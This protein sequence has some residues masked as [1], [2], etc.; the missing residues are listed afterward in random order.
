MKQRHS[1][2]LLSIVFS[3]LC[4]SFAIA[5]SH[6]SNDSLRA[7]IDS[8]IVATVQSKYAASILVSVD[9]DVIL[10]KGYGFA[11]STKQV[12]TTDETLF[13]IASIT[14][15]FTASAI[16]ILEEEGKLHLSDSIS[17]YFH[18]TSADKRAIT[19][20]QLLIHT[21]GLKQ[22]YVSD[23]IVNRDSAVAVILRDTLASKPGKDTSYSNL[24]YEL[25]GA[26]VEIASGKPY[27]EFITKHIFE[28]AHMKKT[29]FWSQADT[30]HIGI[31]ASKNRALTPDILRR[32]WG[33]IGSA[34]IYSN[35]EDLF[36]W[37]I[38]VKSL[39]YLNPKHFFMM[40][41]K[42]A[43]TKTEFTPGWFISNTNGAKEIWTRGSEDWGH[44][45]VVRW[46]P[47]NNFLIIIQT[48]SGEIGS[49]K[50]ATGNRILSDGI[51]KILCESAG[52]CK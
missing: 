21:S 36:R 52:P 17:K 5:S 28:P 4:V 18:D 51:L 47:D 38:S 48:N 34:G 23:G 31:I 6:I 14:K 2:F 11:D 1:L 22:D 10:E 27:E 16:L 42:Y 20:Q 24:N 26:I 3:F 9:K 35:V 33:Y 15:S 49:D 44:N 29:I 45:A 43:V 50:E 46:F 7:R 37:Y 41:P 13:N 8:F 32:N 40:W 30:Q 39:Y 12:P 19:I 25:L